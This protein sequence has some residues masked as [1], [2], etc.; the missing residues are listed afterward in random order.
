MSIGNQVFR[1]SEVDK[2]AFHAASR[3]NEASYMIGVA[4]GKSSCRF[5][6]RAYR[7]ATEMEDRRKEWN[8]LANLLD[9]IAGPRIAR[10]M[11]DYLS[12]GGIATFG[13]PPATRIDADVEGLRLRRPFMKKVPWDTVTDVDLNRGAVRVWTSAESISEGKPRMAIDMHGW[14]AVVLP[15]VFALL[16]GGEF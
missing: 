11:A 12:D 1:L 5:T 7:R 10:R 6:F 14:N 16:R 13:S 9:S 3:I 8:Q 15:R 4:Q 2:I